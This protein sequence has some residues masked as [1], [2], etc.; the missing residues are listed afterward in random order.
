MVGPSAAPQGMPSPPVGGSL[1]APSP[2]AGVWNVPEG[3]LQAAGYAGQQELQSAQDVLEAQK[4]DRMAVL[5]RRYVGLILF[6][7]IVVLLVVFLPSLRHSSTPTGLGR[8]QAPAPGVAPDAVGPPTATWATW[9]A[10]IGIVSVQ[11]STPL[12]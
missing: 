5:A 9:T 6:I 12:R 10:G 3:G 4:G 1:T 7:A 8:M 11:Q 2:P